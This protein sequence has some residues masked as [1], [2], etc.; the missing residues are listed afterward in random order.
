MQVL[1]EE[2]RVDRQFPDSVGYTL[3]GASITLRRGARAAL[4]DVAATSVGDLGV[5][6][7]KVRADGVE[8][9]DRAGPNRSLPRSC[10]RQWHGNLRPSRRSRFPC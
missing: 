3:P 1:Q 6:G 9:C 5:C 7:P 4:R 8:P 10:A 2:K